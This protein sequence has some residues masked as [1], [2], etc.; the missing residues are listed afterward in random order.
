MFIE[1][2]ID[3]DVEYRGYPLVKS[4]SRQVFFIWQTIIVVVPM[5]VSF[6]TNKGTNDEIILMVSVQ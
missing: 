2:T 4:K 5:I 1:F 3:N 6:D